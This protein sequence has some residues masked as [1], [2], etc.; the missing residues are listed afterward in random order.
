VALRNGALAVVL[1]DM[2]LVRPLGLA[3]IR[4]AV[5][6]RPRDRTRFSRFVHEVLDRDPADD[7]TDVVE[8]LE[9]F[10]DRQDEPPVLIYQNDEHLRLLLRHRERL[11]R[12]FR[13][14]LL[15]DDTVDALLDKGR[16]AQLARRHDLPVPATEI[17][18]TGGAPPEHLPF[19]LV[20]KP[21]SRGPAGRWTRSATIA[22]AISVEDP[23]ALRILW[24]GLADEGV[25]LAQH[26]VPGDETR[27][28]SY[29]A[30]VDPAGDT[31]GEFTGRKI[32]TLPREYGFTTAAEITDADDVRHL[33]REIVQALGL[34]GV[35][36]IDFKRDPSGTLFLLEVNP[37]FNLWHHPGALAGVNLPAMVWAD[38]TGSPRPPAGPVR[39]GVRWCSLDDRRAA[40]EWGVPA[41]RWVWFFLRCEAVSSLAIDDPG[42]VLGRNRRP[43][44]REWSSV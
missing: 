5:V 34:T 29:H 44:P 26:L 11:E 25:L 14:D 19:P 37:R 13:I 3:G 6:A 22:K 2:N 23:A 20:L 10:A 31:A 41:W 40:K 15:P 18:D 33:G 4:C 32:R 38:L 36:K 35:V 12:R 28:E 24:E 9:R 27:I 16:F 1:G 21:M 7:D 42:V 17:V 30:Y 8:R 39:A 43:R